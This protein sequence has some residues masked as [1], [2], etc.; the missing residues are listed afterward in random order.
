MTTRFLE[1]VQN[2]IDAAQAAK[3]YSIRLAEYGGDLLAAAARCWS[4]LSFKRVGSSDCLLG[5]DNKGGWMT[6]VSIFPLDEPRTARV[7]VYDRSTGQQTIS[8]RDCTCEADIENNIRKA[9][10]AFIV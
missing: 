5:K 1:A 3:S 4:Q 6:I 2:D 8:D 10:V 7:R 9:I